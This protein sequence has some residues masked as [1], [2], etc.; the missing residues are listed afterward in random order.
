MILKI[1]NKL[2]ILKKLNIKFAQKIFTLIIYL[3][4]LFLKFRIFLITIF[5][6][7]NN[8]VVLALNE[9]K[10]N[11]V[12][13]IKNFYTKEETENI[14]N[15]CLKLLEEIPLEKVK[16]SEYIMAEP[17]KVNDKIFYLE[18]LGKSIKLKGL[19]TINSFLKRVGKNFENNL[20]TLTYHL[21]TSK[22][23][24]VYNVSHDGSVEHPVLKEYGES[25][26]EAI[27]G[28]PH[29]DLYLHKLRCFV[30]LEDVNENNG[31]TVYFNKSMNS[32]ILK[33]NHLN[34]FLNKF[35]YNNDI[36]NSHFI[37][38]NKLSNLKKDCEK[39]FLRCN[40]GDL[41]LIDLKTAHYAILPKYGE[42]QLLWF[43]Y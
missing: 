10:I 31:A 4:D 22:P 40:K 35:E 21:N 30:A 15:E 16:K 13:V 14:K 38:E 32:K 11:G 20:I 33:S 39:S 27:A 23:Y 1:I 34:L 36:E 41:A 18:K 12:S 26:D 7:K 24:L 9:L 29:V 37:D 19:N 42:R 28:R 43:Y 3:D 25:Q 8:R 17:I 6:K 2:T 5:L